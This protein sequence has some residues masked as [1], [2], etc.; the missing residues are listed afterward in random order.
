MARNVVKDYLEYEKQNL[1]NYISII[2]NKKLNNNLCDMIIDTYVDIRYFNTYTSVKKNLIDNIEYYVFEKFKKSFVD[3]N[4]RKNVVLMLDALI[5]IR[6]LIL[7]EKYNKD[8]NAKDGL[9]QY[10][11]KVY[12]KYKDTNILITDLIKDIKTNYHKKEKFLEELLSTDFSVDKKE[13]NIKDVYET[14]LDN[15]VRIPDLFSDFAVNRVYN[16]GTINEDKM[17][18]YYTLLSRMILLDM[19]DYNYINKYLITFPES[20]I[21]RDS[22]L[23]NLLSI[24]DLEYLKERVVMIISYHDYKEKKDSYD[25]LI[26]KGYSFAV[27]IDEEVKDDLVMFNIFSYILVENPLD[28]KIFNTYNNVIKI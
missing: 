26:H 13:T 14:I 15:N 18:V 22:K 4:V 3:D 20:I 17:L 6:Y 5:V 1:K 9:L 21:D 16:S 10:E 12:E 23:N 11:Q 27:I 2:T 24:I 28:E 8:E 19:I 25:F 7:F